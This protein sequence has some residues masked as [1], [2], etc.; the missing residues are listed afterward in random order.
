[1]AKVLYC[2]EVLPDCRERIT[3]GTEQEVMMLEA[4]HAQRSHGL[5]ELTPELQ[6]RINSKIRDWRPGL[7]DLDDAVIGWGLV[8][9]T[10]EPVALVS[11]PLLAALQNAGTAHVYGDTADGDELRPVLSAPGGALVGEVDGNTVNQPLVRRVLDRYLAGNRLRR[12]AAELRGRR[13]ALSPDDLVPYLYTIVCSWIGHDLLARFAG[14]RRWDVSL[15]LHMRAV[16]TAPA[17]ATRLGRYLTQMVPSCLVK[18]PFMP[19]APH[20]LLI[21]RDLERGGLPVNFT[22]TFSA[23]Q[24]V[25]AA[26]LADTSRTNVFLGRLNQGLHADR[27]GEHV[28]LEAQ[29]ALRRLHAAGRTKTMLIAASIRDWRT[30]LHVAGCDAF[31]AP[32]GVLADFLRQA[33]VPAALVESQLET[34]YAERLGVAAAVQRAIGH[35]RLGRL[36]RVEPEFVEFLLAYGASAEYRDLRD[37]ERLARR[38]EAAGF[39]DFFYT[40]DRAEQEELRRSKLPDLDAPLAKRLALDT[41]YTLLADADF[42]KEQAAIDGAIV[43]GTTAAA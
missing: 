6:R 19:Q 42:E 4:A 21:A 20:C 11:S 30:F 35:E 14:G 18:V 31:T 32:P 37:G 41:L 43:S 29:R 1:M 7:D 24:A 2:G 22:S 23:R 16:E 38:F 12:C 15:Q 13:Q 33:E 10:P 25:A 26:L 28:V 9:V 36:W 8:P 3:G 40:P 39:G 17:L 34:S 5:G 27:L